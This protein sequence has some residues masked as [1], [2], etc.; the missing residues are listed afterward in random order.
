[1]CTRTPFAPPAP[2]PA[3]RTRPSCSACSRCRAKPPCGGQPTRRRHS[4]PNPA[5][6]RAAPPACSHTPH[7]RTSPGAHRVVEVG[8]V[9]HHRGGG[10]ARRDP[11]EAPEVRQA[12]HRALAPAAAAEAAG[13]PR[14]RTQA[15]VREQPRERGDR[16]TY[17]GESERNWNQSRLFRSARATNAAAP[18]LKRG[19]TGK[20]KR[21]SCGSGGKAA[22]R[23]GAAAVAC[24]LREEKS[25]QA[26]PPRG[27]GQSAP[28]PVSH[29]RALWARKE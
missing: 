11:R 22:G 2:H 6:R 9:R 5:L 8:R 15:R 20:R 18:R 7:A 19:S 29:Q 21:T 16:A 25:G 28:A 24:S 1:M 27:N 3:A 10:D 13:A 23:G 17:G 26:A 14:G 4:P 12:P